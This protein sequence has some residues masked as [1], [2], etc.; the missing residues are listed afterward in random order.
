MGKCMSANKKH[1]SGGRPE[2][3]GI[4]QQ[5]RSKNYEI[6][7]SEPNQVNQQSAGKAS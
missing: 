3:R 5:D 7:E 1:F 2:K 4:G 6:Y